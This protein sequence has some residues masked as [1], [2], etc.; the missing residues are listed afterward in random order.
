[1]LCDLETLTSN[2]WNWFYL[3]R[4]HFTILW[5]EKQFILIL[6]C[7]IVLWAVIRSAGIP[8]RPRFEFWTRRK[9]S[10][11]LL[12]IPNHPSVHKDNLCWYQCWRAITITSYDMQT[13]YWHP[14]KMSSSNTIPCVFCIDT[15]RLGRNWSTYCR[16]QFNMHFDATKR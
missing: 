13:P 6:G 7:W 4:V 11:C 3:F 2:K 16:R 9:K 12:S 8:E 10:N 1:M 14:L 15:T 5:R